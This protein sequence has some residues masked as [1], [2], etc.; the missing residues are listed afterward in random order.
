MRDSTPATNKPAHA[1]EPGDLIDLEG[2][3]YADPHGD[4][5]RFET[6]W[7]PVVRVERETPACVRL[8]LE[9]EDSYGFPAQHLIRVMR[10]MEPHEPR[11]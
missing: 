6:E 2:D 9:A 5:P 1:I 8:D 11:S 7:I 3:P 4:N 10:R